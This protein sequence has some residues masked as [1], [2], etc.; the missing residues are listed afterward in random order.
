MI[1]I[2]RNCPL[3]QHVPGSFKGPPTPESRPCH[4]CR[5]PGHLAEWGCLSCGW[6]RWMMWMNE[7]ACK[8]S[9]LVPMLIYLVFCHHTNNNLIL[10]WPPYQPRCRVYYYRYKGWPLFSLLTLKHGK[11]DPAL[12][13]VI[14]FIEVV[15]IYVSTLP[16]LSDVIVSK[17]FKYFWRDMWYYLRWLV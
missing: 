16:Q 11:V 6:M 5:V 17:Y 7:D 4:D 12:L 15:V 1:D 3:R 13:N 14:W 10:G 8:T 2:S 9:I